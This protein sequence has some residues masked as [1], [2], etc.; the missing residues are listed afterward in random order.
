MTDDA[1]LGR[2]DPSAREP[3]LTRVLRRL[4][5]LG[6]VDLC[7]ADYGGDWL[8]PLLES[9][10]SR[11]EEEYVAERTSSGRSADTPA[12]AREMAEEFRLRHQA[13]C[14]AHASRRWADVEAAC[15]G[16]FRVRRVRLLAPAR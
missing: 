2:I 15:C 3:T 7:N 12:A 8:L 14:R 11:A 1:V 9:M 6:H 13:A 10:A 4:F 16:R 5:E